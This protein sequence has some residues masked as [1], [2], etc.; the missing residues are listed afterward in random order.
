MN[1]F[2]LALALAALP[3]FGEQPGMQP[4]AIAIYVHFQQ[5]PPPRVL[6]AIHSEVDAIMA[7]AGLTFDWRD[8]AAAEGAKPSPELA[9]LTFKGRCDANQF[10][11]PLND[12]GALG[13][14]HI[15]DGV[16]LPFAD[17]DCDTIHRFLQRELLFETADSRQALFGR[18]IGRVVAHELYH[19]FANTRHHGSE[20]AGRS[21]YS[22]HDLL[23]ETFRF[24][25]HE[26]LALKNSHLRSAPVA[27][28]D[29]GDLGN[30]RF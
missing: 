25:A 28:T 29:D 14:T 21:T 8:L 30:R 10:L 12:P 17:I 27:S 26:S 2:L 6:A 3:V 16:I 22:V 11:T 9:V 24:E 19:I 23:S 7:P 13:W 5:E 20:G 1:A 18:A 15:S 4:D